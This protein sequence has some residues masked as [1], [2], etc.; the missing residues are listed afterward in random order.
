VRRRANLSGVSLRVDVIFNPNSGRGQAARTAEQIVE[1]LAVRKCAARSMTIADFFLHA[2]ADARDVVVTVGGDGTVRAI[3]EALTQDHAALAPPVAVVPLGTANLVARHLRLPWTA[4]S[5]LEAL[6]DAIVAGRVRAMDLPTANGRP[7][8]LMCS[9]GFDAQVVHEL[10]ARR[11]GPIS[12]LDYLPALGRSMFKLAASPVEVQVDG[13]RV[14][15]PEPALV[16]VGN[17]AEYGTGFSLT[18]D[19]ITDDGLLDITVFR[20]GLHAQLISTA[21][22]AFTGQIDHGAAVVTTGR[23]VEITGDATPVQCD[24][25]A[26]EHTPVR[27]ELLPYRQAFIVARES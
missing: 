15:G 12:M 17:A 21:L 25:E 26:F 22:H 27:I 16:I 5:G 24:G 23:V 10:A 11:T 9:V 14:F 18:P 1:R 4:Q 20:A 2:R 3:V 19:A 13:K 7:F 6:A 8:L